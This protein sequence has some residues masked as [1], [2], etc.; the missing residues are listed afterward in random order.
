MYTHWDWEH[1]LCLSANRKALFNLD[2]KQ[3]F[4]YHWRSRSH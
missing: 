2:Y 3:E 1:P 4:E